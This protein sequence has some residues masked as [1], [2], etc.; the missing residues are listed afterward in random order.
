MCSLY[1]GFGWRA[2]GRDSCDVGIDVVVEPADA[3]GIYGAAQAALVARELRV[4]G[5]YLNK[6]HFVDALLVHPLEDEEIDRLVD[7]LGAAENWLVS[8]SVS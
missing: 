8:L 6:D 7:E 2:R 1:R 5:L 3:L 4:A